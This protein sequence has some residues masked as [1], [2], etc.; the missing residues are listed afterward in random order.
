MVKFN[1]PGGETESRRMIKLFN[2]PTACSR[3]VLPVSNKTEPWSGYVRQ[4]GAEI[5]EESASARSTLISPSLAACS[6]REGGLQP[7]IRRTFHGGNRVS[8][9]VR[10]AF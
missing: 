1:R 6:N 5:T 7:S 8:A 10:L 3:P 9:V 2:E 4:S